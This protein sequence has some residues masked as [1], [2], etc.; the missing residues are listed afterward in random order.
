MVTKLNT[1]GTNGKCELSDET[2]NEQEIYCLDATS[3]CDPKRCFRYL[4]I[5][6]N[7]TK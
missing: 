6:Y 4:N 7:S 5:K 1:R 3:M 2:L